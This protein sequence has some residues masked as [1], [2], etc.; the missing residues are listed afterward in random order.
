MF[1]DHSSQISIFDQISQVLSAKSRLWSNT[2]QIFRSSIGQ[3]QVW[4]FS[5]D[6]NGVNNDK[7]RSTELKTFRNLLGST[8]FWLHLR[9]IITC[10]RFLSQG[11]WDFEEW[12]MRFHDRCV[13]VGKGIIASLGFRIQQSGRDLE[14]MK[15]LSTIIIIM[16][17]WGGGTARMRDNMWA[18]WMI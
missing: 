7:I 16:I 3:I 8:G 14:T 9:S 6:W 4:C 10:T 13:G 2:Y 15:P 1:T 5:M 12:M 18:V 11:R 17:V